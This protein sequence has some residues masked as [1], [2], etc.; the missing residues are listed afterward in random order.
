MERII[1]SFSNLPLVLP[2][3]MNVAK[4]D[5]VTFANIIPL[6]RHMFWLAVLFIAFFAS[7][8]VRLDVQQ[9]RSDL[10]RNEYSQRTATVTNERLVLELD[11]RRRAEAVQNVALRMGIHN[12][13]RIIRILESR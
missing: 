2:G 5:Q 9:L 7:V 12:E 13:A 1:Q 6:W 10:D 4:E 11:S 8:Q 3:T